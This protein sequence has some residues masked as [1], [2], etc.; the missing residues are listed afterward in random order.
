MVGLVWF[1]LAGLVI[2][3]TLETFDQSDVWTKRQKDK[4]T[5]RQKDK[6]TKRGIDKETNREYNIVMSGQFRTLT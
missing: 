4:K 2:V 5:K 1:D 3:L 6:K